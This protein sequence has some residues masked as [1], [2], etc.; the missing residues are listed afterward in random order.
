MFYDFDATV[1]ID[2]AL[3]HV[4]AV[5]GRDKSTAAAYA[6]AGPAAI[7][8]SA[9][10]ILNGQR[11]GG[12]VLGESIRAALPGSAVVELTPGHGQKAGLEGV[13]AREAEFEARNA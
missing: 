1:T 6:V 13:A 7:I 8:I 3:H 4:T 12:R 9:R 5:H 11:G 2:G 10:P